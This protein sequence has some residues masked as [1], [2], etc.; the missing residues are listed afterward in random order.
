MNI[1][2]DRGRLIIWERENRIIRIFTDDN[3]EILPEIIDIPIL[4]CII[5]ACFVK[6][7]QAITF[8][9]NKL[10]NR[11]LLTRY[12]GIGIKMSG[13]LSVCKNPND[14]CTL[15]R[16][17]R[18]VSLSC[19]PLSKQALMGKVAYLTDHHDLLVAMYPNEIFLNSWQS[20]QSWVSD[21]S[22]IR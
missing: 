13:F 22:P 6:Y 10:I 8:N 14:V 5:R 17:R 16:N 1:I 12:A 19:L 4:C 21:G 11:F 15:A 20:L 18:F 9:N 2:I 7:I 3:I